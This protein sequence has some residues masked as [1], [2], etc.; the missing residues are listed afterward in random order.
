MPASPPAAAGPPS[1]SPGLS[2]GREFRQ[3]LPV[4]GQGPAVP[5]HGYR[6][7]RRRKLRD[8][9]APFP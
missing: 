5:C 4:Y 2:A 3:E 6:K 9:D 1:R 8:L 7:L